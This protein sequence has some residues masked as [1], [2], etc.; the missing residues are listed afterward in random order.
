MHH[1]VEVKSNWKHKIVSQSDNSFRYVY[2]DGIKSSHAPITTF[3]GIVNEVK[4]SHA[5][6]T[7]FCQFWPGNSKSYVNAT[8]MIAI[9]R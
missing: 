5:L 9:D 2:F 4:S 7:R 6:I 3:D 1:N 8:T